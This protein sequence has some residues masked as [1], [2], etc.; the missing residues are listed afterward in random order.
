MAPDT[1]GARSRSRGRH[2][3]EARRKRRELVRCLVKQITVD[4]NEDGATEVRITYR[5]G[6]PSAQE[7]TGVRTV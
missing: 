5:F 3:E 1:P 7:E 2:R 6:P 4:T